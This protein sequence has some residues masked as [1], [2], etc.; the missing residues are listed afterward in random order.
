MQDRVPLYPGRVKLNPVS[1]QESTY[2]MVRADDPTQKGDPLSKAT[3]LKDATAAL[4]GLGSDAVP[5]DV[6][7]LLSRFQFGLGNEYL[8]AK[9]QETDTLE[10]LVYGQKTL[11]WNSTTPF[12]RTITYS[13]SYKLD[14]NHNVILA[15]PK[16][17]ISISNT[18]YA[19]AASVLAGKYYTTPDKSGVYLAAESITVSYTLVNTNPTILISSAAEVKNV[20]ATTFV[21]YV[22]SPDANAY[23]P[24]VSDGYT[25]NALGQLGAKASIA[26]GSYTGTGTYGKSNPT[27][28]TFDFPVKALFITAKD[29]FPYNIAGGDDKYTTGSIVETWPETFT[30]YVGFGFTSYIYGRKSAD[31][32]TFEWYTS[33]GSD[34]DYYQANKSGHIYYYIAIG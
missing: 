2:D 3:F 8:W 18:S 10:P 17:T 13:D 5:D 1:G 14:S 9:Y 26:T 21:G 11:A 16:S 29:L 24:A 23:P 28:L 27:R 34:Y 20:H 31:C 7:S 33:G 4:Y 15:E 6:L 19:S 12:S 22:N 32:K 30:H 25:Y